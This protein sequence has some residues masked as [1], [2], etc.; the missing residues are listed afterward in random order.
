MI[1]RYQEEEK[2][3]KLC[4]EEI[5]EDEQN[6]SSGNEKRYHNVPNYKLF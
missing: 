2:S 1:Y 4:F 3:T 5:N 6:N